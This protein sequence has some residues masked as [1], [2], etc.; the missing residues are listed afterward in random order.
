M[1][2][3]RRL[4]QALW[5]HNSDLRNL[6]FF[7]INLTRD[8]R[9]KLKTTKRFPGLAGYLIVSR[10]L[11][12]EGTTHGY[13]TML[14][15]LWDIEEMRRK[16]MMWLGYVAWPNPGRPVLTSFL[17]SVRRVQRS[18]TQ[19]PEAISGSEHS[20]TRKI[21]RHSKRWHTRVPGR[22]GPGKSGKVGKGWPTFILEQD[23]HPVSL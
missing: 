18:V 21:P 6:H 11:R 16:V 2:I 3:R 20:R 22:E 23:Q 7:T 17:G 15:V 9:R 4:F 13:I 10:F 1:D 12:I 8:I 14:T 19:M 5:L